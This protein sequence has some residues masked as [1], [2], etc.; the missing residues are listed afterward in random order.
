MDDATQKAVEQAVAENMRS[1]HAA[2]ATQNYISTH[3]ADVPQAYSRAMPLTDDPEI[4]AAAEQAV[5]EEYR[6]DWQKIS[7]AAINSGH[8][9]AS[10][11]SD[12]AVGRAV[13]AAGAPPDPATMGVKEQIAHLLAGGE[14]PDPSSRQAQSSDPLKQRID[15]I[16]ARGDDPAT[17]LTPFEYAM[18]HTQGYI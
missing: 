10:L 4:L 18:A 6:N 8:L 15:A 3:M 12:E 17:Y 2:N 9:P 5:R 1:V 16:R 11:Y 14:L 7:A 13:A